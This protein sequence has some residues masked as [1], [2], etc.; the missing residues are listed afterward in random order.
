MRRKEKKITELKEI[1]AV[2]QKASVCRLGMAVDGMPY[3]VPVNFGYENNSIYVHCARD[4][5][6]LD[7]LRK[8]N[9]VCFEIDDNGTLTPKAGDPCNWGTSYKSIIGYGNAEFLEDEQEKKEGLDI[10]MR[11][12]SDEETFTYKKNSVAAVVII[13]ITI[14]SLSGK[15]SH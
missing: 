15:E 12:Y 3:V 4:G 11:H 14:T 8:N 1:E 13:K 7:M 2:I 9:L 10:I 5:R 6:K